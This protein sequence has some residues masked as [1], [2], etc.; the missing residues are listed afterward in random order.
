MNTKGTLSEEDF[1]NISDTKELLSLIEE[2]NV[3]F[4][5]VKKTL[6]YDK[7]LRLLH[8]LYTLSNMTLWIMRI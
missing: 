8:I 4:S 7:E 3:S 5:K 6:N 1:K 2:K